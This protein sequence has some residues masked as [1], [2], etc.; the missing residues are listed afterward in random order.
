[1]EETTSGRPGRGSLIFCCRSSVSPSISPTCGDS[2][3]FATKTVVVSASVLLPCCPSNARVQRAITTRCDSRAV[4]FHDY[5]ASQVPLAVIDGPQEYD[6]NN[7]LFRDP[8][9]PLRFV[10]GNERVTVSFEFSSAFLRSRL[11]SSIVGSERA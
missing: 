1:V 4:Y 7:P 5:F 11:R 10:A 3:I 8:S 2:R 9:I 6:F